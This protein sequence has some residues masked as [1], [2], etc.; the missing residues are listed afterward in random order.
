M[1][2]STEKQVHVHSVTGEKDMDILYHNQTLEADGFYLSRDWHSFKSWHALIS[3]SPWD[4]FMLW[5]YTTCHSI[6][7]KSFF[8][9]LWKLRCYSPEKHLSMTGSWWWSVLK[10]N[11]KKILQISLS[12]T[13]FMLLLLSFHHLSYPVPTVSLLFLSFPLCHSYFFTVVICN[14]ALSQKHKTKC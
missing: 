5:V 4:I 6:H 10:Q 8:I 1:R 9:V 14:I 12:F 3:I 13:L 11:G 2:F 7:W